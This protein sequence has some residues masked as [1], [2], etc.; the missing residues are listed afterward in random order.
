MR[1]T[2]PTALLQELSAI[3]SCCHPTHQTIPTLRLT[4][5]KY[6]LP[7]DYHASRHAKCRC[8]AERAQFL[9]A[10]PMIRWREA[11]RVPQGSWY[12]RNRAQCCGVHLAYVARGTV[13]PWCGERRSLRS[14]EL[15]E[16]AF[17]RLVQLELAGRRIRRSDAQ[18]IRSLRVRTAVICRRIRRGISCRWR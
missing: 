13:T 8:H 4:C 7:H 3:H 10:E 14:A 16:P 12:A 6:P 1:H 5:P 17:G 11:A 18:R 15:G 2:R 9:G